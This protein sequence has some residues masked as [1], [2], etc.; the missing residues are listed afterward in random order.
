MLMPLM[1]IDLRL[2][3]SGTV[4][5]TDASEYGQGVCRAVGLTASGKLEVQRLEDQRAQRWDNRIGLVDMLG[6]LSSW[7]A[8]FDDLGIQPA[9]FAF[10]GGRKTSNRVVTA[11]WP[12]VFLL[13]SPSDVTPQWM[14]Q[15]MDYAPSVTHWC[16]GKRCLEPADAQDVTHLR[17]L[18]LQ[19]TPSVAVSFLVIA[20]VD[21]S[22]DAIKAISQHLK[23]V[24]KLACPSALSDLY[25]PMLVWVSWDVIEANH[26]SD[27]P[28]SFPRVAMVSISGTF[29]RHLRS[30]WALAGG[31]GAKLP[32]FSLNVRPECAEKIAGLP[33]DALARYQADRQLF[34]PEQYLWANGLTRNGAWRYM[35]SS[36]KESTMG[37]PEG[38]TLSAWLTRD[39][40]R[41]VQGFEIC[42]LDLLGQSIHVGLLKVFTQQLFPRLKHC[43]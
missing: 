19:H 38:F 32:N 41:D 16:L 40:T 20:P 9:I 27:E 13:D 42:R 37:F 10:V 15:A 11:A 30:G 33:P 39:S 2:P 1:I 21:F 28:G 43:E 7:R 35:R 34:P 29:P 26:Q 25:D 3:T 6:G 8:A 14:R 4:V 17:N 12:D 23:T 31:A 18:I 5:A 22:S 24:P 36:E